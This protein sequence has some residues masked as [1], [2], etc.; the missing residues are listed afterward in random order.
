MSSLFNLGNIARVGGFRF[1]YNGKDLIGTVV[2][3]NINKKTVTVL[4]SFPRYDKKMQ[5]NW[6][7]NRTYQVHD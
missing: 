2:R 1:A 5:R 6:S 3:H 4:C 7:I